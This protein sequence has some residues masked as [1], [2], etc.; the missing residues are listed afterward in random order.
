MP[1]CLGPRDL[2]VDASAQAAVGCGNNIFAAH[3][4]GEA[5]NALGYQLWVL[6]D[7][8]CV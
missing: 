2:W 4:G 5:L 1:L 7:V 8:G 3:A 6:N